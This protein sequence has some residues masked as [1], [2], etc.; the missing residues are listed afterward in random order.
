MVG[1]SSMSEQIGVRAHLWSGDS[2][3]PAQRERLKRVCV[4]RLANLGDVGEFIADMD[5]LYADILNNKTEGGERKRFEIVKK[6]TEALR[7]ALEL[8]PESH[9]TTLE[10]EIAIQA[11][12]S[13]FLGALDERLKILLVAL[14]G[15]MPKLRRPVGSAGRA[16]LQDWRRFILLAGALYKK[17]FALQPG[18]D[19][20]FFQILEVIDPFEELNRDFVKNALSE[21]EA[22]V[23]SFR[24]RP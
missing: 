8:L 18:P 11:G 20:E 2:F 23:K 15:L 19:D 14:D 22:Y 13:D 16:D 12:S 5:M 21:G 9:L 1:S 6:K 4:E 7:H 3:G 17:H 24:V 10:G